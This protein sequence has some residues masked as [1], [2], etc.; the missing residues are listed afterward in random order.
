ME[1]RQQEYRKHIQR[2]QKTYKKSIQTEIKSIEN[3][4]KE[5]RKQKTDITSIEKEYRKPIERVYRKQI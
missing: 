4:Y 3:R 2:V 1:N 5:Y